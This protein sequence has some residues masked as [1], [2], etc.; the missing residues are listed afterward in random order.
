MP[1]N[2]NDMIYFLNGND[3]FLFRQIGL[4]E[5]LRSILG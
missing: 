2:G 1:V 3:M 4:I 5:V